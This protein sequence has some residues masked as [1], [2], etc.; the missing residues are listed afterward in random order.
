[1]C[2]WCTENFAYS[3]FVYLLTMFI[4]QC[5]L[6]FVYLGL[7]VMLVA[8]MGDCLLLLL[9]FQGKHFFRLERNEGVRTVFYFFFLGRRILL[10]QNERAASAEDPVQVLGGH[11]P[12]R[13][14]LL[15]FP[16]GDHFGDHQQHLERNFPDRRGP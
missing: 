13:S 14:R 3:G 11:P 1:M 10:E 6:Y 15:R 16:G 8:F 5:S 2:E 9:L 4:L 7:V 12:T